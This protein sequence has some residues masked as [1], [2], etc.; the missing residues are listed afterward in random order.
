MDIGIISAILPSVLAAR[1]LSEKL[2][3]EHL[4]SMGRLNLTP[5]PDDYSEPGPAMLRH[6]PVVTAVYTAAYAIVFTL[7]LLNNS[8]VLLVISRN[9]QMRTVTNYFLANLALADL[10]VSFI[11]LPVTLISNIIFGELVPPSFLTPS[12]NL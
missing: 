6:T 3:L 12:I 1:N 11:V 7:A 8:C 9:P 4:A 5:A 2:R 10:I